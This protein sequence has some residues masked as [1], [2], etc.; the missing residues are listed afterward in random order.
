ML[1]AST[2]TLLGVA[3]GWVWM[4]VGFVLVVTS[5]AHGNDSENPDQDPVMRFL[6][7]FV[8]TGVSLLK[9]AFRILEELTELAAEVVRMIHAALV[10]LGQYM[11]ENVSIEI[12]LDGTFW[13]LILVLI[14]IGAGYLTVSSLGF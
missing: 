1:D 9:I 6:E 14:L 11:E 5:W 13:R 8:L 2:E 10:R 12:V 3:P 7:G 4:L